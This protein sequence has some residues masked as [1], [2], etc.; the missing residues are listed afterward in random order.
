MQ[1][2]RIHISDRPDQLR[3]EGSLFGLLR[4]YIVLGRLTQA[5]YIMN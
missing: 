5:M 3:L 1:H 4:L 2:G